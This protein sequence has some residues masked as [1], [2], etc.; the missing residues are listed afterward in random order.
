[1]KPGQAVGAG[2][3]SIRSLYGRGMRSMY[4]IAAGRCSRNGA[5]GAGNIRVETEAVRMRMQGL[6][7]DL[8][9]GKRAGFY[10]QIVKAMAEAVDVFDRD[11]ELFVLRSEAERER[12]AAVLDKYNVAREPIDLLLLPEGTTLEGAAED[13]GFVAKFGRA[14]L[15]ADRV[16]L[17]RY[18]EAQ[19]A[20]A[21]LEQARRQIDEHV[22]LSF[23]RESDGTTLFATEPHLRDAVEGVA[24]RYGVVVEFP[25]VE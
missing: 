2:G 1:M 20:G 22:V 24:R 13:V 3:R 10:A 23:I 5:D 15:Y 9:E 11:K 4:A 16:V 8:P 17:F 7:M 25:D 18:A 14:Y 21:E 12:A 6:M 19:P